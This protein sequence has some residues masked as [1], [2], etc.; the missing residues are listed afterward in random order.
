PGRRARHGRDQLRPD[1]PRRPSRRRLRSGL[2]SDRGAALPPDAPPDAEAG[3]GAG[4]ARAGPHDEG[5]RRR[6]APEHRDRAEPHP[7]SAADYGSALASRGGRDGSRGRLKRRAVLLRPYACWSAWTRNAS[8]M[9]LTPRIS[10]NAATQAMSRT[11]LR[12]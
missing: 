12:P 9:S 4:P 2:G 10:A 1:L 3:R 6:A 7:P 5:D 8:T 11:E